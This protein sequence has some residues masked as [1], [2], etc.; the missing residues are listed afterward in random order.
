[1][2]VGALC[3]RTDKG[4]EN[5]GKGKSDRGRKGNGKVKGMSKTGKRNGNQGTSSE[6]QRVEFGDT[7][8]PTVH[9][10]MSMLSVFS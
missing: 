8:V 3:T 7:N 9:R 2:D 6:G 5:E 4:A 10:N 1:M